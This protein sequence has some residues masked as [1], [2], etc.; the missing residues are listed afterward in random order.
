MRRRP[1]WPKADIVDGSLVSGPYNARRRNL[2][3]KH[4]I[5]VQVQ[6]PFSSLAAGPIDGPGPCCRGDNPGTQS[7]HAEL[8]AW[9]AKGERRRPRFSETAAEVSHLADTAFAFR[10]TRRP[11]CRSANRASSVMETFYT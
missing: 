2:D 5:A 11:G 7:Y 3:W 6:A 1:W 9:A 10:G 4:A 8:R